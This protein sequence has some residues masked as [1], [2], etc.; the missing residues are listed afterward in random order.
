MH[1]LIIISCIFRAV[2]FLKKINE[3]C[4]IALT[5]SLTV[6]IGPK[7]DMGFP[8]PRGERGEL[9]DKGFQGIMGDMGENGTKGNTGPKGT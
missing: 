3:L 4:V 1:I 9:G 8:G 5:I 7:G 2:C 6:T